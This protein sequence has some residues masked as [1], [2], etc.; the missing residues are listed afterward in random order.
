MYKRI[1]EVNGHGFYFHHGKRLTMKDFN[2]IL[3]EEG[4]EEIEKAKK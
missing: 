2:K 1:G 4:I 3:K